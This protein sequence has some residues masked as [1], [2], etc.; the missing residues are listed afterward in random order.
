MSNVFTKTPVSNVN[1]SNQNLS[2]IWSGSINMGYLNVINCVECLP[3]DTF[4]G[5]TEAFIQLAPMVYPIHHRINC[6]IYHFFV[7]NRI[8]WKYWEKFYS[9]SPENNLPN[10]P[11]VNIRDLY[12]HDQFKVNSLSDQ[13]GFPVKNFLG[14]DISNYNEE[15]LNHPIDVLPYLAYQKIWNDYFRDENL[16]SDIFI[17]DEDL[18]TTNGSLYFDG[19]LT[20]GHISNTLALN[21]LFTLRK[22]AW[23]K[24][25]FTSA[26][27]E[28]QQGDPQLVPVSGTANIVND[29]IAEIYTNYAGSQMTPTQQLM[30]GL[31]TEDLGSDPPRKLSMGLYT[32]TSDDLLRSRVPNPEV[33]AKLSNIPLEINGLT[34]SLND[35][36][37]SAA[38][39][40]LNEALMRCGHRY[41]ETIIDQFNQIIP[42]YTL[43][44]PEFISSANIPVV[45]SEVAQM[46]E[47]QNTPQGNLA[48]R[49]TVYGS[50]NNFKYHCQEHG[51]LIT[52]ACVLPRT[53][54]CQGLSRMFTRFDRYDY[55]NKYL[56]NLGDQPV[57]EKEIY[58]GPDMAEEYFNQDFGY[59][60]RFSEYKYKPSTI[61][62]DYLDSLDFMT[63][64]RFLDA[65]P[66]LNGN[67]ITVDDET[68]SRPFA[69][70]SS[71][72]HLY[73]TFYHNLK[74]RRPMSANPIPKLI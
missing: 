69:V 59:S 1:W 50:Q 56:E 45:I 70:R 13:I 9:E 12:D 6:K 38:L 24:D 29:A 74:A 36:R 41:K 54:Y 68:T 35:L 47:T 64:T 15:I 22:K 11:F 44:R 10:K 66:N 43:D 19:F 42:D 32:E 46:S 34:F 31:G 65:P 28:P 52:L 33:Y 57:L 18:S 14:V 5:N 23:E 40:R 25:Y 4:F 16:Q 20:K 49:G 21:N 71:V 60:P 17:D 26:L 67:F 73:A 61:H 53:M 63:M 58:F 30:P 2:H 27:P 39:Q 55:Y 37:L 7:P 8:L 72:A 3:N 51:F 48:G 62:G